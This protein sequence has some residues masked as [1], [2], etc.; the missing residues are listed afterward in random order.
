MDCS[1]PGFFVHWILQARI[2]EWIA[3]PFSRGTPQPRDQTLVCLTG[4]FFT[5]WA[6][7]KSSPPGDLPNPGLEP[8]PPVSP[9]LQADSL[10]AE[11][12]RKTSIRKA[13]QDSNSPPLWVT[14]LQNCLTLGEREMRFSSGVWEATSWLGCGVCWG[15]CHW[16]LDT[17][18]H[19][20]AEFCC[21]SLPVLSIPC[22][23]PFR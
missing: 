7:G 13:K 11:P 16:L 22:M 2:L 19:L 17:K 20:T 8:K 21:P 4:R 3:I 23:G 18:L 10:L 5:V 12:S 14:T 9:A 15:R 6:T 1:P